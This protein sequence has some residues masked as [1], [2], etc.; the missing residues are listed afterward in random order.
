MKK[1]MIIITAVLLVGLVT[2]GI[3]Y[4]FISNDILLTV[5]ITLGTCFYHFAVRLIVGH[6]IDAIF[7]N[8]MNYN[9]WWF[10]E[11][12]FESR[13]YKLLLVKK[14]KKHMPTY[15][16]EYYDIKKH[17]FEE[18][19]GATC[20]SEVVHEIN[21]VLSFVPVVC[22]IW[23][24]SL[25]AFLITSAVAFLFD[26]IFVIMQRYNRPRLRRLMLLKRKSE[27]RRASENQEQPDGAALQPSTENIGGETT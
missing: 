20:Q 10:K 19:M 22:I 8:K 14:W 15:N 5:T 9:R 7:H 16:S 23:F 27:A 6:S 3:T 26:S 25:I 2:C 24:D 1:N 4:Y 17:S 13:L 11:R 21:M 18:I 12:K